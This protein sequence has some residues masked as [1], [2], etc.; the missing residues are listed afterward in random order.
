MTTTLTEPT[1]DQTVVNTYNRGM[2]AVDKK[3]LDTDQLYALCLLKL[4]NSVVPGDYPALKAAI[5]AITGVQEIQLVIDH[6]TRAT[7]PADTKIVAIMEINLR[8]ESTVT[9]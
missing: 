4:N 8:I 5:E 3:D 1:A 2:V 9:P 6:H 7:V